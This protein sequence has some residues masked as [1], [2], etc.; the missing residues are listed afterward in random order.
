MLPS[1]NWNRRLAS[2]ASNTSS[3]LVGSTN[4]AVDELVESPPFQG[5]IWEFEPP[6]HHQKKGWPMLFDTNK[7]RENAGLAY[8]IAYFGCNGYTV[9]VPLND[10]Q[11]YDLI[12]DNGVSLKKVQVKATSQV[13]GKGE[14]AVS[15]RSTG[16]TRGTAY[17]NVLDTDI[18]LLFVLCSNSDAYLIPKEALTQKSELKLKQNI[19]RRNQ[20]P[21]FDASKYKVH[22]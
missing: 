9:S 2:Q 7:H 1:S 14:Y 8:V 3:S 21:G 15:L 19:T 10:T 16:G 22:I 17:K 4:G 18:D 13:D 20:Y 5:G 11:D 6:Q 12:V